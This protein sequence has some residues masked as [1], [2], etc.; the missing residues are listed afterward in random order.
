VRIF[1][2]GLTTMFLYLVFLL[3]F[4]DTRAGAGAPGAADPRSA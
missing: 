2:L 4:A 1:I 3:P